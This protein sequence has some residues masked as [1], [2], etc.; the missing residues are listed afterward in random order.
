MSDE[1]WKFSDGPCGIRIEDIPPHQRHSATSRDAAQAI[2][3]KSDT[4]RA[5][6]MSYIASQG[7]EGATD[8]EIQNALGMQGSTQR[9]RRIELMNAGEIREIG[10]RKTSSG[11]LASVWGMA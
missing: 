1:L 10:K 8:E 2:R 5:A 11:R 4:L 3:P 9:P 6:V 7:I